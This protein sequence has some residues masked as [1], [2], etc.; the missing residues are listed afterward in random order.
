MTNPMPT[1]AQGLAFTVLASLLSG[2]PVPALRL[3]RSIPLPQVTGG[4]NHHSADG[5]RHRAYLCA[6]SMKAVLVVD[7]PTGDVLKVL[8]GEKPSA[9]CYVAERD[10]ICVSRGHVVDAYDAKTFAPAFSIA[11]PAN[12]D[13]MHAGRPGELLAGAMTAPDEGVLVLDL[14][15]HAVARELKTGI[16][17]QGFAAEDDGERIFV[18]TPRKN[19]VTVVDRG[20]GAAAAWKLPPGQS[21]NPVAY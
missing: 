10:L 21:D 11:T 20:G 18:C 17:P 8:P 6:S 16:Q 12:I 5:A 1:L 13:E 19:Q 7:L 14:A 9:V 4:F 3:E 2:Q 15:A